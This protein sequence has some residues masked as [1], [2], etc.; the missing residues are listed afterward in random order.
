MTMASVS[1]IDLAG[2][3]VLVVEDQFVIALDMEQ[4]LRTL[5]AD[6][7]DLA[8]SISDALAIL[9]RTPPDLAI[10]DVKLGTEITVSIAEALQARAIPLIFVTGYGD[11]DALPAHLRRA[12]LLRKPVERGVLADLLSGLLAT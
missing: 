1:S 12:P 10:L 4:M 9:E 7:V 6:T 11:L 3:R 5:G 8:T 2:R